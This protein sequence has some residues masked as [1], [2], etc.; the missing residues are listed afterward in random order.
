[1][2][3][4]LR[5][6]LVHEL[7]RLQRERRTGA[8]AV[9][10]E[11]VYTAIYFQNGRAVFAD[12][13]A[14]SETLGRVLLDEGVLDQR[15]YD[16]AL[17]ELTRLLRD[18]RH[19]RLGGVL[20]NPGY[21][22]KA[23]VQAAIVSQTARRIGHLMQF[24]EPSFE[25]SEGER[26]LEGVP[27]Y[28]M[29][30]EPEILDGVRRYFDPSRIQR[31]LAP[32]ADGYL[33]LRADVPLIAECFT[34]GDE[35]VAILETIDGTTTTRDWLAMQ[36]NDLAWPLLCSLALTGVLTA[37]REAP[38]PDV[39]EVERASNPSLAPPGQTGRHQM[40]EVY[41]IGGSSAAMTDG[42]PGP[43]PNAWPARRQRLFTPSPGMRAVRF[44][45]RR[46]T[47]EGPPPVEPRPPTDQPLEIDPIEPEPVPAEQLQRLEAETAARR[48][49]EM[50]RQD[51]LVLAEDHFARAHHA[52]PH[53]AE[54]A[55]YLAWTKGRQRP[56]LDAST[57]EQLD[58]LA[59][60]AA[61]QDST[62]GFPP[63]VSG[64][65][66]LARGDRDT[67]YRFFKVAERRDADNPDAR[68]Q[69]RKLESD[70]R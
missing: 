67:A 13:S 64:H 4:D 53:V 52:M 70:R 22:T 24:D 19:A 45:A 14:V 56:S 44:G 3:A 27:R 39:V 61:R 31:V 43:P 63:Y 59:K 33:V 29:R 47:I 58:R 28:P 20:L 68:E 17:A 35:P 2:A 16:H 11:D 6:K 41:P 48:G 18:N 62:H 7:L 69:L 50:L 34:L 25:F 46:D 55:L 49:L 10:A 54:Y 51:Q 26:E 1:M 40:P 65:V 32:Y 38:T 36:T 8:L 12:S 15:Q 5:T 57:L 37:L 23:Q 66:A 9:T 60:E 30:V 42:H 21:A